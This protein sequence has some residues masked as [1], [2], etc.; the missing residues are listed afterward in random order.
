MTYHFCRAY[1][2][3]IFANHKT[4]GYMMD[5][6]GFIKSG[7]ALGAAMSLPKFMGAAAAGQNSS[8]RIRVACVG[9]GGRGTGAIRD[10][11]NADKN[12]QIVALGDLFEDRLRGCDGN[13]RN[14]VN[15]LKEK[16]GQNVPADLYAVTADTMFSGFDCCQKVLQVPCDVVILAAPP[17]FRPDH[18][19]LC[20]KAGKHIFAEKPMFVDAVQARRV[21]E[22]AD[23][24]A[25]KGLTVITGYQRHADVAYEEGVKRLMD[26]QI[27]DIVSA[28]CYWMQ[29]GYVGGAGWG[30]DFDWDMQGFQI[31]NWAA[32]IWTSGDH[33]VEQH[34]HNIDVVNWCMGG[35]SPVNVMGMGGRGVAQEGK[36]ALPYPQ[37]GDRYS[38]FTID[39]D[40]GGGLHV[41]SLCRQEPNTS[42]NVSER[43]VGTKGVL[44]FDGG[45]HI[46][47]ENKWR[48]E[49]DRP[50]P[51]VREHAIL[52]D[53][54]RGGKKTN[55][56][57]QSAESNLMALA[58]RESAYSGQRFKYDWVLAK[59]QQNLMPQVW[60]LKAKKPIGPVPVAGVYE[61]K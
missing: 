2:L 32:W 58:G 20:I 46:S 34:C 18:M 56:L 7:L 57:R 26:G 41:M 21:F 22:L 38:N 36:N 3:L 47:G 60:D 43:I 51:Y 30:G 33:I 25:S 40:Y 9:C 16:H 27:G 59:S 6:R 24:S 5:R 1:Y 4:K 53:S 8:G 39:F 35:K 14:F 42:S 55:M 12:I 48:F 61:L 52:F 17:C 19:E 23:L 54:I 37:F 50:N 49:G 28:Q 45:A 10:A 29:S 31:R 44:T 15:E 13:V 11:I